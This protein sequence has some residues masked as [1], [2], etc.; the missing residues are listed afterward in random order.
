MNEYKYQSFTFQCISNGFIKRFLIIR[1]QQPDNNRCSYVVH[2]VTLINS[3]KCEIFSEVK[4][5]KC[6]K[7]GVICDKQEL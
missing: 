4:V 2:C 3:Q 5:H 7:I 6:D 1:L